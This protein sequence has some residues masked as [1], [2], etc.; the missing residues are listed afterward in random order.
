M[1]IIISKSYNKMLKV[2]TMKVRGNGVKSGFF[3]NYNNLQKVEIIFQVPYA[4]PFS[5]PANPFVDMVC[6]ILFLKNHGFWRFCP[7]TVL[8]FSILSFVV[9]YAPCFF[10]EEKSNTEAIASPALACACWNT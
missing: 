5:Y 8:Y 3:A 6:G 1:P 10:F 4:P 9:S 7:L 2:R